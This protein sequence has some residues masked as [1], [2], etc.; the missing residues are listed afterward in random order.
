MNK[1][2]IRLLMASMLSNTLCVQA[3]TIRPP[4]SYYP[5]AAA[6]HLFSSDGVKDAVAA[7]GVMM[8]V[9]LIHELGHSIAAKS[10]CGVPVDITIGG[11]RRP[12]SCLKFAGVEFAGFNPLE[13]DSRWEEHHKEDGEIYRPTLG[14]DTT[15]LLA[16]PIAQ[17]LTGY[18]LY[19]CLK[20][21]NNFY[22]TKA[23]ALGAIADTIIGINGLYGA[24]Y[25]PW[26]DA[27]KIAE[28]VKKYFRGN[29]V[30]NQ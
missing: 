28:N 17:A 4:L 8:L 2:L 15:V 22:I 3:E 16:G 9:T 13:S 30:L 27:S 20:N 1:F 12:G 21:T 18:C 10:L 26:S 24:R 14:Q 6:A 29:K 23:A 19:N 7:Y 11:K 5:K 25:V